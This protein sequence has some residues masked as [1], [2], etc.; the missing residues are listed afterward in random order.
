MGE[1]GRYMSFAPWETVEQMQAWKSDPAFK[2]NMGRVQA[3]VAEF[4]PAEMELVAQV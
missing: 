3:H 2:E 1:P 4:T